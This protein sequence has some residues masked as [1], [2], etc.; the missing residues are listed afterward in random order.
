MD[1]LTAGMSL[2]CDSYAFFIP[3]LRTKNCWEDMQ[4]AVRE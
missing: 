4:T 3:D 2:E 1:T